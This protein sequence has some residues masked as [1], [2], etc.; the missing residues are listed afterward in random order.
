[1]HISAFY[2]TTLQSIAYQRLVLHAALYD[3]VS[4]VGGRWEVLPVL[5]ALRFNDEHVDGARDM[6]CHDMT[7]HDMA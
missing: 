6:T 2:C 7:H 5:L 4:P 3:F 1:M